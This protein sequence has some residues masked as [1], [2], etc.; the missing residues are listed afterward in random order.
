MNKIYIITI[1]YKNP[2]DTI[3]CLESLK[4]LD[5][6]NF[7]IVL[8]EV[9]NLNNSVYKLKEF[10]NSYLQKVKFI[11]L[12]KNN[13][14]SYA[15]NQGIKY[16]KTQKDA[17]YIWLL[18]NDTVAEKDSLK[19]LL[20]YHIEKSKTKKVGFVGSKILE[21]SDNK[22]IQT[23]GGTFNSKTGY[24]VLTGKGEQDNGQYDKS[25]LRPDYLIGAS[26]FF[27]ISL[28]NDIGLMPEEYFLYY[29]DID[30]CLT[31][32]LKGFVNYTC[33]ESKIYHKQGG[34]TDNKYGKKKS[35]LVTRKYM[36]SS[37]ILLYRKFF[38]KQIYIAYFILMKQFVGRLYHLQFREAFLIVK[39]T[40]K[41]F[42]SK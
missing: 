16:I 14:F 5:Y 40:M 18:N 17:Q 29:E 36:Y 19:S 7:E 35:N 30:W 23:V 9:C 20:K 21:Y 37:Y 15:N 4:Q 10:L 27:H 38:K 1:N 33:T 13:G 34:S 3:E 39:I 31:A 32:K 22:I 8:I 42:F 25:E 12:H 24:S 6:E 26:M 41:S 28:L 11:E 2:Q